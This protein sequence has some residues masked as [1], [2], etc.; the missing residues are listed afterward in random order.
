MKGILISGI[1]LVSILIIF[2]GCATKSE[3]VKEEPAVE[4]T[5]AQAETQTAP[6]EKEPEKME[7][8]T[9]EEPEPQVTAVEVDSDGDG[10]PDDMD[11]CPNTPPGTIVDSRGCPV[12]KGEQFKIEYTVEF[13][14]DSAQIK[15]EYLRER[16]EAISF[17]KVHPTAKVTRVI[18]EGYA[19]RVGT[20]THNYKLSKRRAENVKQYLVSELGIDPDI[21]GVRA[22]GEL[23]PIAT[24]DTKEGR[25][26]NRRVKITFE[27]L[28]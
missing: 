1:V 19:D 23:Y 15:P 8:Q 13:D 14:I 25:R 21:I 10:I 17:M 22:F 20:E 2:S 28:M 18:V 16:A 11:Q 26:K 5:P 3:A 7:A 24:N 27:G 4:E 9:T 6:K 12:K